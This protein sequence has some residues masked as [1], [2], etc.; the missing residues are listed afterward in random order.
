MNIDLKMLKEFVL[1]RLNE[2]ES[3]DKNEYHLLDG[4][5]GYGMHYWDWV[6]RAIDPIFEDIKY[7]LEHPEVIRSTTAKSLLDYRSVEESLNHLYDY[8]EGYVM[9]VTIIL[10]S[11]INEFTITPC[12]L[13][14]DLANKIRNELKYRDVPYLEEVM[15]CSSYYITYFEEHKII[16]IIPHSIG[17]RR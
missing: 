14:G 15:N 6:K 5:G 7:G 10:D 11:D 1:R 16:T 4:S 17:C 2:E 8:Y 9:E 12:A 3:K 13:D